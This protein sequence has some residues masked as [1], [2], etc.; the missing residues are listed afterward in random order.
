M[1]ADIGLGILAGC[2]ALSLY[3]A[4]HVLN[5]KQRSYENVLKSEKEYYKEAFEWLE[6]TPFQCE[7]VKMSDGIILTGR[8]Y[9]AAPAKGVCVIAHGI[10]VNQLASVKYASL[11]HQMGYHVFTYDQRNHGKSEGDLTTYGVVESRDLKEVITWLY[12][13]K[14]IERLPLITHGESMGAAT[15]LMHAAIDKRIDGVISDCSFESFPRVLKERMWIEKRI[16]KWPFLNI[17]S[18][19]FWLKT[20]VWLREMSPGKAIEAIEK[21]VLLIHGM[22][23]RYVSIEHGK[24][25]CATVKNH[26]R[27]QAMWVPGAGHAKSMR[28]APEKYKECVTQW[29]KREML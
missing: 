7:K 28:Q 21:P 10:R 3:I 27:C 9:A 18:L 22:A 6:K 15:V 24:Q 2:L 5:P 25:L 16:P 17:T 12:A 1:I 4:H 23:D 14:P 29:L 11:F 8:W 19:I 20:G 13:H 26:D